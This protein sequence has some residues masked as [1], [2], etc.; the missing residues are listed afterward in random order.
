MPESRKATRPSFPR[1][2]DAQLG[3]TSSML[4]PP[5]GRPDTLERAHL[6]AVPIRGCWSR[7]R[8]RTAWRTGPVRV[9]SVAVANPVDAAD[10]KRVRQ[11]Q[12]PARRHV[13]ARLA[14][15][16]VEV[17]GARAAS[18]PPA[19]YERRADTAVRVEQVVGRVPASGRT[20]RRPVPRLS[21]SRGS[22]PRAMRSLRNV[23]SS[24]ASWV[25]G[26]RLELV[27][28]RHAPGIR[29]RASAWCLQVTRP[30]NVSGE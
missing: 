5:I 20:R 18:R 3:L 29:A 21:P 23:G 25:D 30:P 11:R 26:A 9:E 27:D 22:R 19:R 7:R 12:P 14:R 15:A 1:M 17:V 4:N 6:V 10:L 13:M 24:S 28:Q 16:P 8:G 2:R